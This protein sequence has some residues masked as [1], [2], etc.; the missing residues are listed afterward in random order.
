MS[1]TERLAG[2]ASKRTLVASHS[3]VEMGRLIAMGSLLANASQVAFASG[4][5]GGG[6]LA[7]IVAPLCYY[8][9]RAGLVARSEMPFIPHYFS[10]RA[11]LRLLVWRACY[12]YAT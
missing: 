12:F 4:V 2:G 10:E 9:S 1:A 8:S 11:A 6:R 5:D 3:Q 7:I